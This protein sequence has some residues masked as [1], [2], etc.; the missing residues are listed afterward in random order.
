[1]LTWAK[2]KPWIRMVGEFVSP[3]AAPHH[4]TRDRASCPVV[5]PLEPSPMYN[6]R[7]V[8]LWDCLVIIMVPGGSAGFWYQAVPYWDRAH[9]QLCLPSQCTNHCFSFP[10]L[11]CTL[12]RCT[13]VPQLAHPPVCLPISTVLSSACLNHK[14][15]ASLYQI[16]FPPLG[17]YMDYFL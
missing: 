17:T 8:P 15:P 11:Y 2:S 9:L 13:N 6:P 16:F 12:A 5:I 4:A 14:S 10:S 7:D 3:P 1:M